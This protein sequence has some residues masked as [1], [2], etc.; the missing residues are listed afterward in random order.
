MVIKK[1]KKDIKSITEKEE[2]L[3]SKEITSP[4]LEFPLNII[5]LF[6]CFKVP[7][8]EEKKIFKCKNCGGEV[9]FD[10]SSKALKCQYCN[11]IFTIDEDITFNSENAEISLEEFLNEKGNLKGYG[12]P[13]FRFE[14]QKCGAKISTTEKRRDVSC[15]FC[16]TT[17]IG[18]AK[19]SD[20]LLNINGIIPFE[21]PKEKALSLFKEWVKKGFFTPS[22][23]K[24]LYKY[25]KIFGIYMPFF[26]FD[27]QTIS[28][29][30]ALSG[31]YYYV[32]ESVP[33]IRNGKKIYETRRVKKI[34][35]EPSYGERAQ[36]YDDVEIP[37]ILSERLTYLTEILPFDIKKGLKKYDFRYLY[38]FGVYNSELTLKE[39]FLMAKSQIYSTEY[40]LCSSEVPGDTHKDL[41]V[42]TI[43][44]NIT[45]KHILVPIWSGTFLYNNKVYPFIINGQTGKITGKKPISVLKVVGLVSSIILLIIILILILYLFSK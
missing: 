6:I 27:A 5:Y 10:I 22:K 42:K 34:R 19:E 7:Y 26:T 9:E 17:Y 21:I 3:E 40:E 45:F 36:S 24:N 25:E 18:E 41:K 1:A 11:S 33:I 29:W 37:A 14:C 16:G 30:S 12:I 15:P 23:L 13:L 44:K 8:M 4:P 28:R 39:A 2:K 32:D 35:W 31:Y 20:E 43:L 38:G